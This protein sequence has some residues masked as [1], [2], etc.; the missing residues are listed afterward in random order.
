MSGLNEF[1][2][3]ERTLAKDFLALAKVFIIDQK[4]R[5]LPIIAPLNSSAD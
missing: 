3:P 1:A 2:K 5:R 4:S